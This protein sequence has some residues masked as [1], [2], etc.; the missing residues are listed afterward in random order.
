MVALSSEDV[1]LP[2]RTTLGKSILIRLEHQSS[3]LSFLSYRIEH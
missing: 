3:S 1:P 2:H